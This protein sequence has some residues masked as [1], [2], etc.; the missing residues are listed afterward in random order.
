[1]AMQ[2]LV[3]LCVKADLESVESLKLAPGCRFCLDLRE[4]GG[5]E[6]REKVYVDGSEEH[7]LPGSRGTAH[8]AMKWSKDSKH[9]ASV[10]VE[11]ELKGVIQQGVTSDDQGAYVPLVGFECRGIEPIAWHPENEF[12]VQGVSG[13]TWEDVDLSEKEWF[14]YDEKSGES[15]SVTDLDYE[16]RVH[17][18]K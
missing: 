2:V 6:T 13:Q 16:F 8:F 7:E 3:L 18:G 1:M 12:V 15:V 14:E 4:S 10:N 9:M 17:K 11:K 5:A